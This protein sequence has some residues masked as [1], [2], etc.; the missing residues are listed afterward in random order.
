MSANHVAARAEE[1]RRINEHMELMGPAP[2][3]D[4]EDPDELEYNLENSAAPE[5]NEEDSM[6][7]YDT[8]D[9]EDDEVDHGIDSSDDDDAAMDVPPE[10]DSDGYLSDEEADHFPMDPV[11]API[12][13]DVENAWNAMHPEPFVPLPPSPPPPVVEEDPESEVEDGSPPPSPPP[14]VVH[15]D[16]PAWPS[17]HGHHPFYPANARV[18]LQVPNL[19]SRAWKQRGGPFYLGPVTLLTGSVQGYYSTAVPPGFAHFVTD[20]FEF[21]QMSHCRPVAEHRIIPMSSDFNNI[22]FYQEVAIHVDA[23]RWDDDFH[24]VGRYWRTTWR[25]MGVEE[26]TLEPENMLRRDFPHL[27]YQ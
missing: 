10:V 13:W 4:S 22:Q 1:I 7:D 24:P 14:A 25:C 5:N 9:P 8:E 27:F 12:D 21:N 3:Y 19:Y 20:S 15:Y 11:D 16:G 26:V 17:W 18:Y 23:P 2:E 6:E